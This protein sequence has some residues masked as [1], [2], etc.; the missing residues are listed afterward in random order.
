[1]EPI[2]TYIF[3]TLLALTLISAYLHKAKRR[4]AAGKPLPLPK[5]TA[6]EDE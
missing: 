4:T 3:L 5:P 6:A 1:M 2:A